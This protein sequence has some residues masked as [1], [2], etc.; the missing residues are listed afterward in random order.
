MEDHHQAIQATVTLNLSRPE[1]IAAMN[2]V[3]SIHELSGLIFELRHNL[4]RNIKRRIDAGEDA[5]KVVAQEI[6]NLI[7]QYDIPDLLE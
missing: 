6:S 2:A 1:G 3:L 7:E 4:A 5:P